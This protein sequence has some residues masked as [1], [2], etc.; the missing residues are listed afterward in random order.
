ME[1]LLYY[2]MVML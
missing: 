2:S 1:L